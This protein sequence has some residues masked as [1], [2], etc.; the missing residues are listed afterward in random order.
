MHTLARSDRYVHDFVSDEE[1]GDD[2]T[3]QSQFDNFSNTD[4]RFC[5]MLERHQLSF[6]EESTPARLGRSSACVTKKGSPMPPEPEQEKG[7]SGDENVKNLEDKKSKL[8]KA[9]P[10]LGTGKVGSKIS[11]GLGSDSGSKFVKP[12]DDDVETEEEVIGGGDADA[13]ESTENEDDATGKVTN[14]DDDLSDE[15]TA[16]NTTPPLTETVFLS[17]SAP[18]TILKSTLNSSEHPLP[19]AMPTSECSLPVKIDNLSHSSTFPRPYVDRTRLATNPSLLTGSGHTP[20]RFS[21]YG[22]T[23]NIRMEDFSKVSVSSK[24]LDI[25]VSPPTPG[26]F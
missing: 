5:V 7:D 23:R 20:A 17:S 6:E 13:G 16:I 25:T 1:D 26:V 9:L 18:S 14:I 2:E 8:L 4:P 10:G 11:D 24:E 21:Q 12:E 22:M 19:P 15:D 3:V